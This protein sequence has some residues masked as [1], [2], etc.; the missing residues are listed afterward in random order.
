LVL[1][2]IV[3]LALVLKKENASQILIFLAAVSERRAL[4]RWL[5][6]LN[7]CLYLKLKPNSALRNPALPPPG[8]ADSGSECN[9][10]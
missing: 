10:F 7:A 9:P 3:T 1:V 4:G 2:F 8:P 5:E 6:T